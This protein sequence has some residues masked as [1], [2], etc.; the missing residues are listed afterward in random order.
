[1]VSTEGDRKRSEVEQ[2]KLNAALQKMQEELQGATGPIETMKN[3]RDF[4][5]EIV[6]LTWELMAMGVS[7]NIVGDVEA[8]CCEH[9]AHRKM[10]RKPSKSTAGR[11]AIQSKDVSMHHLGELLSR[12]AERGIGYA[13]DTTTVRSAERAANNFEIR[14]VDGTVVKLRGPVNEL[15]S[16]TADEQMEHNI[17]YMLS[18]TRRVIETAGLLNNPERVSV[19]YFVRVM[20]DHVNES[21]WDRVEVA[22]FSEL[23]QLILQEAIT[24]EVAA[25]LRFFAR[26]KCSKHKLAKLSR[27][28]CNAMTELQ[29]AGIA[30]F[31]NMVGKCGRTYESLGYKLTEV[32]AWQFSCD[33]SVANPHGHAQDFQDW[34]DMMEQASMA[35]PNVN[36]NRHYRHEKNARKV[37]LHAL[38]MLGYLSDVRDGRDAKEHPNKETKLGNADSRIW[39]ALHTQ[40]VSKHKMEPYAQLAA[41]D[42]LH[43]LFYAPA[44]CMLCAPR[45]DVVNVGEQWRRALVRLARA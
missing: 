40:Y 13:T 4:S 30:A 36:K 34:Q 31:T 15:A 14:L 20:G 8:L 18:D 43:S 38:H 5:D 24:P 22:K 1:M 10:Q 12:N 25:Q 16:H 11:W 27:D 32:A 33:M 6:L 45:I 26:T 37:L 19:A 44:L 42:M 23:E 41:M 21:L 9:L 17:Q 7:S 3:G 28:A 39:K 29:D 2:T 35:M